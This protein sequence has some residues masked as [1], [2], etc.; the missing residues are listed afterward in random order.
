MH[1]KVQISAAGSGKTTGIVLEALMSDKKILILTYTNE[2][3]AVIRSRFIE[4][5]G[6]LPSNVT[7]QS[8]FSFLLKEWVR[9]FQPLLFNSKTIATLNFE[10]IAEN[11]KR[12]P[13][14]NT[15]TYF[16]TKSGKIY[17]DRIS[18]FAFKCNLKADG[19]VIE[20]LQKMYDKIYIDEVQDMSGWDLELLEALIDDKGIEVTFVGDIRQATYSTNNSTKN[21]QFKG[22]KIINWFI[23]KEKE[24]KCTLV[25]NK[26]C[27][28]CNQ[29]IC[30]FAD[31]L[32]PNISEKTISY[33]Y[34]K[35]GHDGIFF[36]PPELVANYIEEYQPK[37]LKHSIKVKTLGSN[38]I[39]F[40][41]SKGHTFDR[42]LMYP[43]DT[44]TSYLK[45]GKLEKIKAGKIEQAFDIAKLYVALTRAR[46][47]VAIVFEG[48]SFFSGIGTYSLTP[49]L[50]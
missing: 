1:S 2:N 19:I 43:T 27:H 29:L 36:V 34:E 8:W 11:L 20:R 12:V 28:R 15:S 38:A 22:A 4:R 17:K 44:I 21:S 13:E 18:N 3:I 49:L 7:V 30:D 25:F 10:P 37:I 35:T 14:S 6:I 45:D 48:N 31:L 50:Q 47:S 40:G 9:P 23:K 5:N 32:Y 26:N 24:G 16:F 42:V 46:Y 39:N 33:N 41:Q